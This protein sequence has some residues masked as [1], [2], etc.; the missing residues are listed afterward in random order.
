M[1]LKPRF[2]RNIRVVLAD[3]HPFL[4]R[5]LSREIEDTSG[6]GLVGV[7]EDGEEALRLI[8]T[9]TPDV[10]LLD[11]DMPLRN[12]LDVLEAVVAEGLPTRLLILT[13]S[14]EERLI[15]A[16]ISA[17]ASGY[18][19]KTTG[20]P[21]IM[22]AIRDVANGHT[23]IDPTMAGALAKGL[24]SLAHARLNERE[25]TVLC[26]TAQ[27][28]TAK[29]IACLMGLGDRMVKK[30]LTSIYA[31]L[32]VESKRDAVAEALRRGLVH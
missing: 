11:I 25:R 8:R 15:V 22:Q 1:P 12:G 17:G 27:N 10:A 28:K 32:G 19:I 13:G 9:L 4:N 18:L 24:L 29:E 5:G 31:K 14:I 20:W 7:A 30:H 16:A 3:D 23:V 26:L 21:E 6:I 2:S